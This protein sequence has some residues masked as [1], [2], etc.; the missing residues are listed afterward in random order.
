QGRVMFVTRRLLVP[1]LF[2]CSAALAQDTL[3]NRLESLLDEAPFEDEIENPAPGPGVCYE[4]RTVSYNTTE[5]ITKIETVTTTHFCFD[6]S[7]GFKCTKEER[8]EV[9]VQMPAVKQRDV[10]IAV[11]CEKYRLNDGKCVEITTPAPTTPRPTSPVPRSVGGIAAPAA[12]TLKPNGASAA[13]A[14]FSGLLAIFA[15]RI[16]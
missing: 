3:T 2:L 10:Q 16:L 6:F 8:R 12:T 5:T 4:N 13:V 9:P 14:A 1:L 7:A 11:C 15:A